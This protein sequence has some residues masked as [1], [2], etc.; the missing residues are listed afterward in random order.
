MRL[1]VVEDEPDLARI[2]KKALVEAQFAVDVSA[3]GIDAL[4]QA[5]Q[6]GYD[7]IVLDLVVPGIDGWAVLAALRGRGDRTPVLILT[8]RDAL[9]ER[10]RGLNAGADDY[11]TKPFALTELIAR[12]HALIR[13]R[14]PD[15]SPVL[16]VGDV[17][18]DTAQRAVRRG[19]A[20]LELTAREYA[21]LELLLRHKGEVVTRA[22][23]HDH[24]YA[25]DVDVFSNV[26]D[27]H[28]AG[29]RR[30]LGSDIIRTR[31]GHGYVVD[32]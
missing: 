7:A 15:P 8:A 16:S 14:S 13:R 28:V 25:D 12:I 18:V 24:I 2:L 26:V 10:V 22:A 3:D 9:E 23:I 30:K 6:V 4:H 1:L 32:A 31:R 20:L 11:V 27:V 21:I 19:G 29:L 5:T 17:E